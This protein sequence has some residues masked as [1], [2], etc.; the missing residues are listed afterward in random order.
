V[1][2]GGA[3]VW[4]SFVP[5]PV[6][7]CGV[8]RGCGACMG[9]AVA[10]AGASGKDAVGTGLGAGLGTGMGSGVGMPG[11]GGAVGAGCDAAASTSALP[12]NLAA[13]TFAPS[14]HSASHEAHRK[15]SISRLYV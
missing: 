2:E 13:W 5:A 4:K 1:E 15:G 12:K 7:A 11:V 14:E 9:M 8:C 6:L 10:D 3:G